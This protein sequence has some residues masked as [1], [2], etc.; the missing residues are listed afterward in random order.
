MPHLP[1]ITLA[2]DFGTK[3]PY[4]AAVK[5]V[6]FSNLSDARIIDITHQL[7]A[8]QPELALPFLL[9]SLPWF[10]PWSYH[11]VVVDPG[12]G[13][14]RKGLLLHTSFGWAIMPDNGLP[15]LIHRWLGP[16]KFFSLQTDSFPQGS[17]SPTFQ[18]RDFFAP[19]LIRLIKGE[20]PETFAVP[21]ALDELEQPSLPREGEYRIWNIDRFG[22]ILLGFKVTLPPVNVITAFR[23]QKIP[24]VKKY[25]DV[26]PGKLGVLVNSS[27]WIEIFCREGSAAN[28][29]DCKVGQSIPVRI[30]G[31]EGQFL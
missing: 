28:T 26:F 6:F 4:V 12:V 10:P 24:Y 11:L 15:D 3:D 27:G 16:V 5:G 13:S 25:Q 20:R 8:F 18:A 9:D 29:L 7:P 23:N 14:E 19:A 2:T 22:N 30:I 17:D 31:G 21:I 1:L